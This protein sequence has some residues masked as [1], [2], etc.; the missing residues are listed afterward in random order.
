MHKH[1]RLLVSDIDE[2]R[3]ILDDASKRKQ[4]WKKMESALKFSEAIEKD[5]WSAT[6]PNATFKVK[7][8]KELAAK[9]LKGSAILGKIFRQLF[10]M[11]S[12]FA[13]ADKLGPIPEVKEV[14][15][16]DAS[17]LSVKEFF[18]SYA[19]PGIPVIITGLN[20]TGIDEEPWT[21]DFFRRRCNKTV[22]VVKRN[23]KATS[24]GRLQ[25]AGKLPLAEFIDSFSTNLTRRKWYLHDWSLPRNCPESLGSP[26]F[27]G[28]TMPKYFAG[29]YFQRA[30]F[31]GYRHSWPSLFIG[32]S[33]TQS[34]MHIDSGNTN[35]WLHLLSGQKEWR[36]YSRQDLINLYL[37][38]Q[39]SHFHLDV[40][41]PDYEKLPLAR[42]AQQFR[43][44]QE[45]GDLMFIPAANP[46]AVKN[47]Q[48]IHGI[49]MNYVDASNIEL[50]LLSNIWKLDAENVE[51]Y[52]DGTSIPHGLRADQQ[53]MTFGE[54]KAT[55]WT[56]LDY[57][58]Q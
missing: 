13:K 46:H 39:G 19:R 21:L 56:K 10:E 43:G 55:D 31:D 17:E 40:F 35:F 49:S 52:S 42:H 3:E 51:L 54:W 2:V 25:T 28:Y 5:A 12:S 44:I 24:W 38:P 29:D 34:S 36:F 15:R 57:D 33:D 50:S 45:A 8:P 4:L 16:R 20:A 37:S 27:S 32:S 1:M 18:D 53:P 7:N 26:P 48:D 11:L 9:F 47:I 30:A 58:L 23:P 22:K 14:E 41:K 6:N